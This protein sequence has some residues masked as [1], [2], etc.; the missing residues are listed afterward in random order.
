MGGRVLQEAQPG[1]MGAIWWYEDTVD[2]EP[3]F[4]TYSNL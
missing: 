3:L 4:T 1:G 2:S